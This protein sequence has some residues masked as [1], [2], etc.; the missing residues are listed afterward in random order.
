MLR[1]ADQFA[2]S[3]LLLA[4]VM[5]VAMSQTDPGR[6]AIPVQLV[7]DAM[8]SAG[9]AVNPDQIEFLSGANR[10]DQSAEVRLVSV[11]HGS[12]GKAKVKLRCQSNHQCLPFYVLVDGIGRAD[13]DSPKA[14]LEPAMLPTILP[15]VIRAGDHATL[16]L[17]TGDA[18][19]SFPVICLQSG[20]RGQRIRAASPD[21]RQLYDAE[22]VAA[23]MLRGNF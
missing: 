17:E 3:V 5:P 11:S 12:A 6:T 1:H 18:R 14:H 2:C 15:K 10:T 19:M 23:G 20:V 9:M 4:A 7:A 8:A 21:R 13:R 22:V 16:V